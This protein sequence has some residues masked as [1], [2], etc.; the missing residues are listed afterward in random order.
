MSGYIADLTV[1]ALLIIGLTAML[2]VFTNGIGERFF[3]GRNK[4][5]FKDQS[6]SVQT[7]WKNVGGKRK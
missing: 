5:E 7:G 6:A 4:S 3:G 2:G 1:V